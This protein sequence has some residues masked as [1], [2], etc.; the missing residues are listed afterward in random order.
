[1]ARRKSRAESDLEDYQA[2]FKAL[3]HPS[4]R[5]ILVVLRARGNRMTAGEIHGRFEH[6]WPTI[7]RHLRQLEHAGLVRVSVEGRERF[8][9]LDL[10]RLQGVVS[11]WMNW[12]DE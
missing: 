8:Y 1:M 11:R 5:H 9:E 2:V 4:R 7:S 12:F 3:G 6:T 10:D